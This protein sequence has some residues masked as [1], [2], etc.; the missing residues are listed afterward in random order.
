MHPKS[1]FGPL[2]KVGV[3]LST[4]SCLKIPW[5]GAEWAGVVL[6]DPPHDAVEM[7]GVGAN[8]PRHGT[9]FPPPT[10]FLIAPHLALNA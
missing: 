10:T 8:P 9:L 6:F 4:G 5:G 2:P 7:E 3:E 1:F